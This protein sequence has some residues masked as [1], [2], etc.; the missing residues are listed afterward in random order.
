V[1]QSGGPALCTLQAPTALSVDI[2]TPITPTTFI[3][4]FL[5]LEVETRSGRQ[6]MSCLQT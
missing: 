6:Q 4:D 1:I 2:T 3:D 5:T